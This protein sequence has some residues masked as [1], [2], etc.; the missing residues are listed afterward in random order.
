[1]TCFRNARRVSSI[2]AGLAALLAAGA[3]HGFDKVQAPSLKAPE[4]GSLAGALSGLA[5]GPADV[6]R[7][8]FSLAGPF[9]LPEERGELLG[10]PLPSYN[11]DAGISVWGMGWS[12]P[13][14]MT[15]FRVLGALTWD[16]GD[17]LVGPFGR[18]TRGDDG[19]FYALGLA[20]AVRAHLAG[21][22]L[23]VYLPDGSTYVFGG[24]D[25]TIVGPRGI[26]AWHLR[27]VEDALGRR[28]DFTWSA[29]NTSGNLRLDRVAWGG[30]PGG[31]AQYHLDLEYEPIHAISSRGRV[32]PRFVDY[33]AGRGVA[34]DQR[35]TRVH[36]AARHAD[37]GEFVER[38]Q[39]ELLYDEE[40]HGAA[41]YLTSIEKIYASSEREPAVTYQYR[42]ESDAQ[43]GAR[44]LEV[45]ML[46]QL[47]ATLG[48]SPDVIQPSRAA[49]TDIDLDGNPD[50]EIGD[51]R[52]TLVSQVGSGTS[53]DP[54]RF[55][56]ARLA[57]A[58]P[59]CTSPTQLGC[60][61]RRCRVLPT[62]A[63][64]PVAPRLLSELNPTDDTV[65]VVDL[66]YA[67]TELRTAVTLCSREGVRL[68]VG[69]LS[70]RWELSP[71]TRFV[72]LNHDHLPDLVRVS[73]S[74][75]EVVPAV[76]NG[77][78]GGGFGWGARVLGSLRSPTGATV[79]AE[80]ISVVDLN[81]DGHP[82]LAAQLGPVLYAFYGLGDGRFTDVGQELGFVTRAG[83]QLGSLS[84]YS[85][86]PA[87]LNKD[88]LTD[89]FLTNANPNGA[90]FVLYFVNDGARLIEAVVP[91]LDALPG[92]ASQPLVATLDGSGNLAVT[93]TRG[94][95]AYSIQL[96][97]PATGLMVGAD[98]GKGS[99]V[100]LAYAR[101]P[102]SPGIRRRVPL[103]AR[104][105]VTTS[106]T[107][108][109]TSSYR[110]QQP[111]VHSAGKFLV[112]FDAVQRDEG[113]VGDRPRTSTAFDFENGDDFGGLVHREAVS[114]ARAPEVVQLTTTDH[115]DARFAGLRWRRPARRTLGFATPGGE[116]HVLEETSYDAYLG[117]CPVRTTTRKPAGTLVRA[118]Q[119]V[120]PAR[121][122]EHLACI[123]STVTETGTHAD[124]SLDFTRVQKASHDDAG[125]LTRLETL[126]SDETLVQQL[127]G[128]DDAHRLIRLESPGHGVTTLGY[129]A[130][131]G[132]LVRE[133]SPEG[134]VRSIERIDAVSDRVLA[135]R[136]DRGG[137]A[138]VE[139]FRYD[140]LERLEKRWDDLGGASLAQPS[141]RVRY[142]WA[143]ASTPAAYA[144][145]TL[146]DGARGAVRHEVQLY[147]GAA[148][149]LLTATLTDSGWVT[150]GFV[151]RSRAAGVD[152]SLR[153]RGLAAG[154]DPAQL[155][156]A[157]LLVGEA[158]GT[159]ETLGRAEHAAFGV[160]AAELTRYHADV[161]RQVTRSLRIEA[162][163]LVRSDLEN[164]VLLGTTFLG[165]D[166]ARVHAFVDAAGARWDYVYDALDRLRAVRLPD[167]S[168]HVV[169]YDELGRMAS[170]WRDGVA[171]IAYS[172]APGS[173]LVVRRQYGSAPAAGVAFSLPMRAVDVSYDPAGRV[174]HELHTDLL[175]GAHKRFDYGYDA[176][177]RGVLSSVSGDGFSKQFGHRADG[178]LS[179]RRVSIDGYRTLAL[180]LTYHDDGSIAG[181]TVSVLDAAGATLSRHVR[182]HDVD[183]WGRLA[184]T[185]IDGT[186]LARYRYDARG[187]LE[188]AVFATGD[189]VD[190]DHDGLTRELTGITQTPA[191][192][193]WGGP[194]RHRLRRNPRG[195]TGEEWYEL[196][197]QRLHRTLSYSPRGFLSDASDEIQP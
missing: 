43:Q 67:P 104:M 129:D 42:L 185:S 166:G 105:D 146:V 16:D 156:Y 97:E 150:D 38:W 114:E 36:V 7:G 4:R 61:E 196:G 149:R 74:N 73:G 145:D 175:S 5:L 169:G 147:S 116:Q 110:Y 187:L 93:L 54:L 155:D 21:D 41:F 3:A 177:V 180:E 32:V 9:A 29:M 40:P 151:A 79:N 161:E 127:A 98:D 69:N 137:A 70:G 152:Q 44:R 115:E 64:V 39:W 178:K 170:I 121:F 113:W 48:V 33:R 57:D 128:Y 13:L 49:L 140:G 135:V 106:G 80:S 95:R 8:G 59:V 181:E 182:K 18:L 191:D 76:G 83:T 159:P 112:G 10:S 94:G 158:G 131:T 133:V 81:G 109:L 101:G 176:D 1:M 63:G 189:V 102:A 60:T 58:A 71:L 87:D 132:L 96:D 124:A 188:R 117:L 12:A 172:Y 14:Q 27:S 78:P 107:D 89:F 75:V 100:E 184:V 119:L 30:V 65:Y 47:F 23:T 111:I 46:T 157:A 31:P 162:G 190:L 164:G 144:V 193:S 163:E 53:D 197:G 165:A 192:A 141:E 168:R 134:V 194:A 103:L 174:L 37:S 85:V 11:P 84:A 123:E 136:T 62:V 171:R 34:L 195:L 82:D 88:G 91:A 118:A 183:A 90:R 35:V 19:D 72:D 179:T 167:G 24:A 139:Q 126:G 15:R 68:Q 51:A 20:T 173:D 154:A 28:S 2:A 125:Q 45:P 92:D 122:V 26:Y 86:L 55:E 160:T 143:T 99:R 77:T 108:T 17:D 50:F 22:T 56:V 148:E 6:S 130:R 186:E 153:V 138:L 25:A 66:N 142:T 120:L 52:R